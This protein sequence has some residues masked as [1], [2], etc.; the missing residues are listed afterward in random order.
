MAKMK[1]KSDNC[2]NKRKKNNHSMK[3]RQNYSPNKLQ[4][5]LDA[6][7]SGVT[8]LKA[9][10]IYNIPRSTLISKST[11]ERPK[12][13]ARPGPKAVLGEYFKYQ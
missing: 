12:S 13:L 3:K 1:N 10:V 2:V 7:E 9:S 8:A 11:G 4:K 6:M 5:A